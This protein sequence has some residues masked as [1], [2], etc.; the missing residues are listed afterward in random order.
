MIKKKI[1]KRIYSIATLKIMKLRSGTTIKS[2]KTNNTSKIDI[3]LNKITEALNIHK[4]CE[5]TISN[6]KYIKT[7]YNTLDDEFF[8]LYKDMNEKKMVRFIIILYKK[9][10]QLMSDLILKTY[11]NK[12]LSYT[13][14]EKEM[15]V[16]LLYKMNEVFIH[17]R[18]LMYD[19]INSSDY[20]KTLL[21]TSE[22][23]KGK[24][25][26]DTDSLEAQAYYCYSH[27]Y[28]NNERNKYD[29]HTYEDGEYTYEVIYDYY[30]GN[31]PNKN[32]ADDIFVREDYGQWF[33]VENNISHYH[34]G[35]YKRYTE[36][37]VLYNYDELRSRIEFHKEE[38][39]KYK[40]IMETSYPH[41]METSYPYKNN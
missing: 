1:K 40:E 12:S 22:E 38:L 4:T 6:M 28:C 37:P 13:C 2:T 7:I 21:K 15:I 31:N 26:E 19:L 25:I 36:L 35:G 3:S 23:N 14:S 24:P 32:D 10:L 27:L 18:S 20:M 41:I 9:T 16:T 29:I 11:D 30:Y 17:I 34:E 39:K 8:V 33:E 5:K